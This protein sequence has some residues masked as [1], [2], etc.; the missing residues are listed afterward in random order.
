MSI[1]KHLYIEYVHTD[2]HKLRF[3]GHGVLVTVR[4][5]CCLAQ[6]TARSLTPRQ[7]PSAALGALS[8]MLPWNDPY[9]QVEAFLDGSSPKKLHCG[10]LGL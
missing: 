7:E 1:P 6:E 9:A 2:P 10:P 8:A 3:G 5:C 4:I